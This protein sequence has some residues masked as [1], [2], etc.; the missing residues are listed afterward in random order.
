MPGQ[1]EE[2]AQGWSSNATHRRI[3]SSFPASDVKF[4]DVAERLLDR[5][6]LIFDNALDT[7]ATMAVAMVGLAG[8]ASWPFYTQG[9]FET[10]G[11]SFLQGSSA[12][13]VSWSPILRGDADRE[14]WGQYSVAHGGAWIEQG[15]MWQ[16]VNEGMDKPEGPFE[17]LR[18]RVLDT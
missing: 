11:Q 8:N 9:N 5:A 2:W 12:D 6:H 3:P 1:Y 10:F 14:S 15:L 18:H 16:V 4:D 7:F 17:G 13:L